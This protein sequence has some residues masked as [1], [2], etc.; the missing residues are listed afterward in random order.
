LSPAHTGAGQISSEQRKNPS[1]E[2]RKGVQWPV[3]KA[4]YHHIRRQKELA[5]KTR[6]QEKQQ[7]RLAAK[8]GDPEAAEPGTAE[9]ETSELPTSELTTS[10]LTAAE[11]TDPG[12]QS[13][14]SVD[15]PATKSTGYAGGQGPTRS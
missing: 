10:D 2:R 6:K 3:A 13:A 11:P 9:L 14:A 15:E 12:A 4:N 7:K 1:P 8:A 5:R